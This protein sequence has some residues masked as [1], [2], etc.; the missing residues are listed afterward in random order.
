MSFFERLQRETAAERAHLL[1]APILQDAVSGRV[2]L[3]QYTAFLGQ[4]FHHVRH[5]VPLLMACGARLPTRHEALR[6]A[7]AEYI[8]E[9]IG[10][11][12][13]ILDD[14]VACGGDR[15]TARMS[16]PGI[17]AELMVAFAHDWIA[18]KNPVGFFGMVHVLEG[19]SVSIATTA[20]ERI[21]H[22]LHLPPAAFTY[23]NSHGTLDQDH[24]RFFATLMEGLDDEADRA[25]VI[26]VAR[27][28]YRLYGDLFRSLPGHTE[29]LAA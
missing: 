19:T 5:T 1:S 12:E 6:H 7:V 17:E 15:E 27:V 23:L 9:E 3:H 14:I 18:R 25:A 28:M 16:E 22:A 20:A 11:E 24:V 13:W 8:E 21:A 26:H 29:A 10:H 2:T 4:A